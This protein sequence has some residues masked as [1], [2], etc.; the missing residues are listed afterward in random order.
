MPARMKTKAATTPG[1]RA[2][3]GT[4]PTT[5]DAVLAKLRALSNKK[6]RDG[7]AHFGILGEPIGVS[8]PQMRGLAR[9]CGTNHELA[10]ELWATG[11]HEA[12]HVACMVADPALVT[13][14]LA[15]VWARDLNSWD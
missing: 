13:G 1:K 5:A 11:V 2:P 6:Y 9:E 4:A 15:D 12:R 14:K 10:L 3:T 8:A 7:M